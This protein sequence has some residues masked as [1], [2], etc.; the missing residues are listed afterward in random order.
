MVR[1]LPLA[2][3][4]WAHNGRYT[5]HRVVTELYVLGFRFGCG[6]SSKTYNLEPKTYNLKLKT[7]HRISMQSP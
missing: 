2:V 3:C 4:G 5:S 6:V 1:G 7:L